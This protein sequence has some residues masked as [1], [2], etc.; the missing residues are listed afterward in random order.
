MWLNCTLSTEN[1]QPGNS[2]EVPRRT[3]SA[4]ESV[5]FP[6]TFAGNDLQT[7]DLN[8]KNKTDGGHLWTPVD[9]RTSQ[10]FSVFSCCSF[11]NQDK[12]SEP[13][14]SKSLCEQAASEH[15]HTHTHTHPCFIA[16]PYK[17][18]NIPSS[19]KGSAGPQPQEEREREKWR[20]KFSSE[21]VIHELP[22]DAVPLSSRRVP[23]DARFCF[24]QQT[25]HHPIFF[26]LVPTFPPSI[27][28]LQFLRSSCSVTV[29]RCKN[30]NDVQQ[31]C[32][33]MNAVWAAAS[34]FFF[35][36][37]IW[38]MARKLAADW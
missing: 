2:G 33:D 27:R 8:E 9:L 21:L 25:S 11:F 32:V 16:S 7:Y 35:F 30:S 20:W 14:E 12:H 19:S 24:H 13:N 18:K 29:K 22:L 10:S 38:K 17:P 15:N 3:G 31:E 26:H 28:S 36:Q 5:N 4:S 23:S 34:S 1:S 6:P 37:C